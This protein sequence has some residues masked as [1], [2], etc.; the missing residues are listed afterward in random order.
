MENLKNLKTLNKS[1]KKAQG[2]IRNYKNNFNKASSN[3]IK[4]FY[5]NPSCNKVNAWYY[6]KD[7]CNKYNGSGL[8]I[9]GGNCMYFSAG[10]T[11]N[12]DNKK[13]LC[14]ITSAINYCIELD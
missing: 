1:T 5:K 10:F 13:Y 11:F 12:N 8:C 9:T 2:F 3:D 4:T 6:C 7:L 14:Y